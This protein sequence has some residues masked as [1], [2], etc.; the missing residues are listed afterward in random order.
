MRQVHPECSC[1]GWEGGAE[2]AR[3][4][5]QGSSQPAPITAQ[6]PRGRS[7]A[8]A[9]PPAG[10]S[11]CHSFLVCLCERVLLRLAHLYVQVWGWG[12]EKCAHAPVYGGGGQDQ[13]GC[14]SV[15]GAVSVR[16][17]AGEERP[18]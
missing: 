11:R 5:T 16:A 8:T 2:K 1:L 14:I 17:G 15:S 3:S 4:K 13:G 10:S 9:E 12:G 18:S 6:P 7:R